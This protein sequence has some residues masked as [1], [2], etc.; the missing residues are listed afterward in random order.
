MAIADS[1]RWQR[2]DAAL[3][4]TATLLA[5]SLAAPASLAD[6]ARLVDLAW[7]PPS[8]LEAYSAHDGARKA[9][10]VL[11]ALP[12]P[13]GATWTQACRWMPVAEALA[14]RERVCS[15]APPGSERWL[16]IARV[17]RFRATSSYD[18]EPQRVIVI[19]AA[20]E[21]LI[22]LVYHPD[23]GL[24]GSICPLGIDWPSYLDGL[25]ARLESRGF[26]AYADPYGV[27]RIEPTTPRPR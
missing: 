2:L 9:G 13:A 25:A 22:A 27:L 6:R 23:E 16:P 4:Q 19:D 5:S 20:T 24:R 18:A 11:G 15:L 17:G 21:A 10:G 3:R 8:I 14:E 12:K 7:C 26:S 1:P